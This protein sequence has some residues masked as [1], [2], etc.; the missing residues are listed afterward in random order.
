VWR[1]GSPAA[2]DRRLRDRDA[3]SILSSAESDARTYLK[4]R[5][6]K[7]GSSF[8]SDSVTITAEYAFDSEAIDSEAYRRAFVSLLKSEPSASSSAKQPN[9]RGSSLFIRL[10]RGNSSKETVPTLNLPSLPPGKT[11]TIEEINT[12]I[13]MGATPKQVQNLLL[14]GD[15]PANVSDKDK[16][17]LAPIHMAC[18]IPEGLYPHT[19]LSVFEVLVA[20]GASTDAPAAMGPGAAGVSIPD[21]PYFMAAYARNTSLIKYM[22]GM[23]SRRDSLPSSCGIKRLDGNIATFALELACINVNTSGPFLGFILKT[24]AY[25]HLRAIYAERTSIAATARRK[26]IKAILELEKK[27][28]FATVGDGKLGLV[29]WNRLAA[30]LN[31]L[32]GAFSNSVEEKSSDMRLI[33]DVM[34]AAKPPDNPTLRY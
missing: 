21:L 25:P 29:Y 10:F 9:R 12:A 5:S 22:N 6:N 34:D 4:T 23:I 33:R 11:P 8:T 7:S 32:S 18:L 26:T 30:S 13:L 14:Q 27:C 24:D 19:P 17:G 20:A 31:A 2:L 3:E 15:P 28:R 16:L 1:S